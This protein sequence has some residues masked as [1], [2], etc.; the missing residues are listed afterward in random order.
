MRLVPNWRRVLLY[1]TN[2]WLNVFA[3]ALTG[4]E[5][6]FQ[7]FMDNPPVPR[8]TFAA[9]GFVTTVAAAIARFIAQESV[10]GGEHGQ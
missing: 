7:V 9:A 4:A 8:G 5:F 2:F 1:S 3:A 10:S 6:L